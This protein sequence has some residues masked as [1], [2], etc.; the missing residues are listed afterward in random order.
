M[1]FTLTDEMVEWRARA[2]AFADEA[3]RPV[4]A[5]LDARPDPADAW[6]WELVEEAD[7]RGLRQAPLPT[8]FKGAATDYVTNTLMLEE[9][10]AADLGMAVVLAQHWKFSQM[11]NELGTP[12]QK[13]RYLSR[14]AANPHGLFAASFTEPNAASDNLL[15]YR[16]PG[17]GMQTFARRVAGG[18]VIDG[19]KH[20]ISNANRADTILCFARTDREGPLTE[21]VT[22]FVVPSGADGL[23]IGKVHDKAGERLANNSEIFYEGVFVPDEDVL[24]E[25]GTA[26]RSVARLLRASNAYAAACALGVGRECFDRSLRW[27]RERVQGGAPIIQHQA[28]GSYL[29]TMYSNVEVSRTLIW[30]AA[31]QA[32]RPE[33]FSPAMAVM[34]KLVA[35]ELTFDSARRAMELWGGAGVMRENGIEKLLRDAAIWLHSDGTNI[36]MRERLANLLRDAA[37]EASLWDATPTAAQMVGII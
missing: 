33:T 9:I 26:L 1:E 8:E 19:M 15:P 18:Y 37:P 30:R 27:C 16:A 25:P 21:S 22:A 29:A 12:A 10:A 23:R 20:Y 32:R 7:G 4:A 3:V 6:S 13:E 24:G 5:G 14:N 34:P 17:A 35:S 28:V 36:I 31:W 11:L 2:R